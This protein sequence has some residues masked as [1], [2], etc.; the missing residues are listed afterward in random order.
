LGGDN[1]F[2]EGEDTLETAAVDTLRQ[3]GLTL[4]V[5]ESCTGGLV[6]AR[7]IDVSGVSDLFIEGIVCYANSSKV[8]RLGVSRQTLEQYGAVSPETAREM[9]DGLRQLTGVSLAVSTT[10]IAGPGGGTPDKPVG[11][12]YVGVATQTGTTVHKL[13]LTGDRSNIRHMAALNA[14]NL[15]RLT[16]LHTK[17]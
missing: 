9:A 17:A 11:L 7:L 15:I 14:I 3:K 2:G 13:N 16:A 1:S 12:V 4:A 8:D 6:S 5:A 10:G